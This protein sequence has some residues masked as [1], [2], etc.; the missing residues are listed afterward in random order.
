MIDTLCIQWLK[1]NNN[2]Y[3][4]WLCGQRNPP[5]NPFCYRAYMSI[6]SFVKRYPAYGSAINEAIMAL[7][8]RAYKPLDYIKVEYQGVANKWV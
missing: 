4:I 6:D 1:N 5:S 7:P 2:I 3:A 8:R